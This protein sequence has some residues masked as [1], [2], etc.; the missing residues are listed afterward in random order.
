M[1]PHFFVPEILVFVRVMEFN[2]STTAASEPVAV[3]VE[4]ATVNVPVQ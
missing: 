1:T 4:S 3:K 2:P